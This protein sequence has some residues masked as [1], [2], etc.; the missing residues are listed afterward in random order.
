M[1]DPRRCKPTLDDVLLALRAEVREGQL[2]DALQC[3]PFTLLSRI[4]EGAVAEVFSAARGTG[5]G[6]T[7][8]VKLLRAGIDS[9][10]MLERFARE[11]R[12]VESLAHPGIVPVID[13][14]VHASGSPWLAMPLVRGS[15]VTHAADDAA[16]DV[17]SRLV[18]AVRL[19]SAIAAAH[20]AGVVHRDLKPGNALAEVTKD[21]ALQPRVIDFGM[22]RSVISSGMRLTPIS[23]AHRMG[24]PAYMAPEQWDLGL[25]ACDASADVF[26]LGMIL[27]E[28][29]CGLVPRDGAWMKARSDASA[30]QSG[31]SRS[32]ARRSRPG[33]A[34]PPTQVLRALTL[35]DPLRADQIAERR[36][37][38]SGDELA[39]KIEDFDSLVAR[40]CAERPE[41][42]PA[43][44]GA[45][46]ALMPK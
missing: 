39:A 18:L 27:G 15:A 23:P 6:A 41:G 4:G 29:L 38:R 36:R 7:H 9:E 2:A 32:A 14:G 31:R 42:R 35:T 26:A 25:A 8:A 30:A 24:T 19:V 33:N 44:A 13:A 28:L 12:I 5:R 21:G 16:L 3:G 40:C 22:A 37:C 45:L 20:A 1:S 17:E 34:M 11:R 10:E 46:L 43:D